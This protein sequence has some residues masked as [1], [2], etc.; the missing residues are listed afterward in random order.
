M[1]IGVPIPHRETVVAPLPVDPSRVIIPERAPESPVVP[2]REPIREP[3][4]EPVPA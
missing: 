2:E 4:P 3:E 1:E